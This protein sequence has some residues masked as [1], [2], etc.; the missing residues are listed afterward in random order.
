MKKAT[1]ITYDPY[2]NKV[3]FKTS[4]SIDG[5]W[6]ELAEDSGL[7]RYTEKPIL[8][9]NCAADMVRTI[10]EYHNSVSDGLEIQFCGPCD[11]YALLERVAQRDFSQYGGEG[12]LTCRHI[13]AFRSADDALE[14]VRAAHE[15]ISSEFEEY[16]PGSDYYE[17]E[18]RSIGDG[19]ARFVE[20]IS[21][22]IPV[23]VV[24]NYSVGKSALINSLIGEEVLPSEINPSTAKNV[25]VIRSDHYSAEAAFTGPDGKVGV[26]RFSVSKDGLSLEEGANDPH[27][28]CSK[29]NEL[30]APSLGSEVGI[31]RALLAFLNEGARNTRAGAFLERFGWNVAIELPFGT[32]LLERCDNKIVFYDTPGNDNV[33]IDQTEHGL[34][35]RNLLGE[36]T[37]ALPIL[38]T[39]RDRTS[40]ASTDEIMNML[41]DYTE[42]FA[43]PCCLIGLSKCDQL[44][45]HELQSAVSKE[46]KNWHGKSIV[47]FTTPVGALG[48]RKGPDSEWLDESYQEFYEAWSSKQQ[49]AKRVC[50]PER[51]VYP[52]GE[53]GSIDE[54]GVCQALY[55]TGIPSLE[56][57]IIHYI[58]HY[59]KYKKSVR[60]RQDLLSS[61]A[62][63]KR[64]L[65]R[66]RSAT[67]AAKEEAARR[68]KA[69]RAALMSELDSIQVSLTIG[70]GNDLASEFEGDLDKY[71]SNLAA[72]MGKIYDRFEGENP[73]ELDD[74]VNARIREHCQKEL[75]DKV[76]LAQDGARARILNEMSKKAEGYMRSLQHYVSK[77]EAHFTEIGRKRLNEK[78]ERDLRPPEFAEVRSVLDGLGEIFEKLA[79]VQHGVLKMAGDESTAREKWL[80]SKASAFETKLRGRKSM[81]GRPVAGLFLTTVFDR[82]I[83]QY[84]AQLQEWAESYKDYIKSQLDK[85]NMLLS[86]MEEEIKRLEERV[87]DLESRLS[88]VSGVEESLFNLLD[89]VDVEG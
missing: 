57:E 2:T 33:E 39:C 24:G 11:D 7:L 5:P 45:K 3:C 85:D 66:Q 65:G 42:N 13:G 35:L 74:E 26:Y 64:E 34:A 69:K 75:I 36:Q 51:N 50:L 83:G 46:I 8:F 31:L 14:S 20:T 55:D 88:K 29:L 40:G 72:F 19:I 18:D 70:L 6:S 59:S 49:G 10:N 9:S 60:G 27:G 32:S 25:R 1:R 15:A 82:P 84:F 62:T 47:L 58:E 63:V 87:A 22:A 76:Y 89:S 41:D 68:K 73:I 23:C 38:V 77:N 81:L 21:D 43:S 48:E 80:A 4:Q 79:L 52:C 54:L 30:I 53:R 17:N 67:V 44:S 78:L 71:C 12:P 56:Y 61:L 28:V 16:L 86:D 37:N